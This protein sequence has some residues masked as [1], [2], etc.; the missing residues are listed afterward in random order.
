MSRRELIEHTL[1]QS[2]TPEYLLVEDESHQHNV[3]QGAE[4][5]FKVICVSSVFEG[6]SRV[7]RH[8]S[9]YQLLGEELQGSLHAL[10]LHLYS[11]Q[12]WETKGSAPASPACL[13]GSR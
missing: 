1:T 2:L 12:E 11:P 4:S 6:L 10:A 9:I 5:H 7:K 8:Q 3:P 13:G